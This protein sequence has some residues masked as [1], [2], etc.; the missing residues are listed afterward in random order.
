[1]T[2]PAM[3]AMNRLDPSE[4]AAVGAE[5]AATRVAELIQ[6]LAPGVIHFAEHRSPKL[7]PPFDPTR[8]RYD[9]R[10]SRRPP[11]I[12]FGAHGTPW[13]QP[14]ADVIAEVRQHGLVVW[15]HYPDP[16]AHPRATLFALAAEAAGTLGKFWTLTRELLHMR[17]DDL[18]AAML[19]AGVDPERAWTTMGSGV[20]SER[21]VEDVAGAVASGVA[22]A[23]ALYVG[24]IRYRGELDA[25]SVSQALAAQPLGPSASSALSDGASRRRRRSSE[26]DR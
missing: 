14:L 15:R 24:D 19:R 25:A 10:P 9:G 17:H 8:D 26:R 12:V 23:P 1:M 18:H 22:Y 21:I 7:S 16:R 5:D 2:D 20:G 4:R 11:L 13:S 6:R 3:S